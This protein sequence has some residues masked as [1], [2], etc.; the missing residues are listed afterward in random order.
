MARD[1]KLFIDGLDEARER[2]DYLL[3]QRVRQSMAFMGRVAQFED[4]FTRRVYEAK[5]RRNVKW[6]NWIMKWMN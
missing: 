6:K 2:L 1:S 3:D 4:D 5:E